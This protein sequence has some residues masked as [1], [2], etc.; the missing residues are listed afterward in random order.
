MTW[1]ALSRRVLRESF[2]KNRWKPRRGGVHDLQMVGLLFFWDLSRSWKRCQSCGRWW[3]S[4]LII[5][6]FDH[7]FWW[8][9]HNYLRPHSN[10]I[11]FL[12]FC[13]IL[14]SEEKVAL[15]LFYLFG[16]GSLQTK[17]WLNVRSVENIGV[18]CKHHN[19]R[20]WPKLQRVS[21]K[22]KVLSN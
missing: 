19:L 9:W 5:K 7:G 2:Q 22:Q 8:E 11:I 16:K 15:Q 17:T 12:K 1:S 18:W 6:H 21:K 13:F 10:F 20:S 3:A 14:P 4:E